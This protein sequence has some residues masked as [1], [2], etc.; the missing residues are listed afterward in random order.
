MSMSLYL[1]DKYRKM[2]DSFLGNIQSPF[3]EGGIMNTS[4]PKGESASRHRFLQN[5]IKIFLG[6][7]G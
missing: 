3:A 7:W 6:H 4:Q 5:Y 1:T 2:L